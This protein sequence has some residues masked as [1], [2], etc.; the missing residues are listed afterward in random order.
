MTTLLGTL[1]FT[2][3]YRPKKNKSSFLYLPNKLVQKLQDQTFKT[4]F[5]NYH[6]TL[7]VKRV[8]TLVHVTCVIRHSILDLLSLEHL[9]EYGKY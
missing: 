1:P 5:V 8:F 7:F 2:A 6:Y 3:C 4:H 9:F